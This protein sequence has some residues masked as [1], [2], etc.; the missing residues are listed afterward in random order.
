M[1]W[2]KPLTRVST[3]TD[4]ND[5]MNP[6]GML[7]FSVPKR[8]HLLRI[9]LNTYLIKRNISYHRSTSKNTDSHISLFPCFEHFEYKYSLHP[10]TSQFCRHC[11]YYFKLK[12]CKWNIGGIEKKKRKKKRKNDKENKLK[13]HSL[14][15]S[16][17]TPW[18]TETLGHNA[19]VDAEVGQTN[20]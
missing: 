4:T 1:P 16:I 5:A 7:S 2:L 12:L 10:K 13:C 19:E 9:R 14:I 3:A 6:G 8:T 18:G 17:T 11:C 15:L 20:S